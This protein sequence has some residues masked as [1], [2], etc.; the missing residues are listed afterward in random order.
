[1]KPS[2]RELLR[3][4]RWRVDRALHHYLYFR[5]YAPYTKACL[6]G[7][8]WLTRH[9][10]SLGITSDAA[11][12]VFDRYHSKVLSGSDARKILALDI[13]TTCRQSGHVTQ[14]FFG[15]TRSL[16]SRTARP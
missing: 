1:M 15:A 11:R 4:H 7:V 14:A 5:Y 16:T 12:F 10:G 2:T 6:H 8:R 9:A 3:L 13:V